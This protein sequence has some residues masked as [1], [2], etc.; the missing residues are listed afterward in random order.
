MG[1]LS[2]MNQQHG[3]TFLIV[4][5]DS[6]IASQCQRTITMNDGTIQS[7]ARRLEREEE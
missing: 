3:T 7:D 2:Q 1:L 4:T 5:H 6:N